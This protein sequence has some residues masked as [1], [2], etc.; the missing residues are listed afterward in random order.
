MD[1]EVGSTVILACQSALDSARKVSLSLEPGCEQ[2][3]S[4]CAD[5][6]K[7]L[8]HADNA[9][10]VLRQSQIA[11]KAETSAT[12]EKAEA[13]AGKHFDSVTKLSSWHWPSTP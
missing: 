5:L 8:L 2:Y 4:A 11:F 3:D 13:L 9:L 7:L 10:A 1:Q 6:T 12:A